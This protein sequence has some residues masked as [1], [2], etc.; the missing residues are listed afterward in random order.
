M[1]GTVSAR[2]S[3]WICSWSESPH[4]STRRT[5]RD[6]SPRV[7]L[8][9]Q[10]PSMKV[11]LPAWLLSFNDVPVNS[12]LSPKVV[13]SGPDR[14]EICFLPPF[15][16]IHYRVRQAAE[17]QTRLPGFPLLVA[18]KM[19]SWHVPNPLLLT[20]PAWRK[21]ASPQIPGSCPSTSG[22]TQLLGRTAHDSKSG[23]VANTARPPSKDKA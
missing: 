12:S 7:P 14:W 1:I 17:E 21:P 9:H 4:W 10:A 5:S 19:F 6:R 16:K 11:W 2:P 8:L 15:K 23:P 18:M 22:G 3:W 13:I 20:D